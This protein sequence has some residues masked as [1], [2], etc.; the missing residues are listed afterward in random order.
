M[1]SRLRA[2]CAKPESSITTLV[3]GTAPVV[4]PVLTL[5]QQ[6]ANLIAAGLAITSTGTPALN[7]TYNVQ[8][9]VPFDQEQ[10][11]QEA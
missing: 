11:A 9:G 2:K 5:V 1:N 8:S 4:A 6:A 10:I 7:G 3:A